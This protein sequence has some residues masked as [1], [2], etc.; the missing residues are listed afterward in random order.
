ML[1]LAWLTSVVHIFWT[2]LPFTYGYT[3]LDADAIRDLSW[4]DTWDFI[5]KKW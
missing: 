3:P 4:K 5:V 1:V 2:F